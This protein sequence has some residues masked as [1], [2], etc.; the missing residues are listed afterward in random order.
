MRKTILRK[1]FLLLLL[2]GIVY[3]CMDESELFSHKESLPPKVSEAKAWYESRVKEGYI[4]WKPANGGEENMLMPDWG[5]AFSNENSTWMVTEVHLDG[6]EKFRTVTSECDERY[7]ETGDKRYMASDMR[8]V[9]RTNKETGQKDGFI[10]VVFPDLSY[11][12]KHFEHPLK[13]ISYL[14]RDAAFSGFI[15]YHDMN[16]EFVNGWIYTEEGNIHA[17]YPNEKE[18]TDTMFRAYICTQYCQTTYYYNEWYVN[19]EYSWTQYLGYTTEC[20][21]SNCYETGDGGYGDGGSGGGG[22][23]YGTN[24]SSETPATVAPKATKIFRNSNMTIENWRKLE[25][26]LEKI[27]ADCLGLGLYNGLDAVLGTGT[28]TIQFGNENSFSYG[29]G[30]AGITLDMSFESNRL[31]HEMWHVY[32]A[33]KETSSSYD[34]AK[35]NLE[36]EARYAQY[37]YL[38]NLP[39]YSGSVWEQWYMQDPLCESIAG[40]KE[41]VNAKGQLQS[42]ATQNGLDLY[43][44][45]GPRAILSAPDSAYESYQYDYGRSGLNNFKNLNTL[46]IGC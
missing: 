9:V 18:Q 14:N 38:H 34:Q 31:F 35:S 37:L 24:P 26:I 6:D 32:Q 22:S 44:L 12:E 4:P 45:N 16:G 5:K 7:R 46:S 19:G 2:T 42:G 30:T 8:L 40:L 13:D 41:Y 17:V 27:T 3:A 10:M 20:W 1:V 25:K 36:I 29:D 28:L 43:M 11:L 39:E 21:Y 15:Y 33:Y 23:N